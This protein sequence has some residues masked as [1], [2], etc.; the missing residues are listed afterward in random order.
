MKK[1]VNCAAPKTGLPQATAWFPCA[2]E[3]DLDIPGSDMLLYLLQSVYLL[4]QKYPSLYRGNFFL[5]PDRIK[6]SSVVDIGM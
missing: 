2:I 5:I 3:P 1:V 4:S 6:P